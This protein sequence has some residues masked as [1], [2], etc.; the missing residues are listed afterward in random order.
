M[1]QTEKIRIS[2]RPNE[3][4]G[5][6]W[7]ASASHM[8]AVAQPSRLVDRRIASAEHERQHDAEHERGQ[9]QFERRRHA[10][11]HQLQARASCWRSDTPKSPL[12]ALGQEFEVL[13][14]QRLI[15][16]ERLRAVGDILGAGLDGQQQ[17]GRIAGQPD[18]KER[19]GDDAEDR[20]H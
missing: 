12:A 19:H 13:D 18:Q 20:E 2:S 5:I 16:P 14:D 4:I 17:Q 7:R 9:R 15:E 10:L 6:A 8:I 1:S 11:E 3:N